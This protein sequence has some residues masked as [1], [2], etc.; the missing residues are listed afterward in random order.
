MQIHKHDTEPVL[1]KFRLALQYLNILLF[2][3]LIKTVVEARKQDFSQR[4]GA[5][6]INIPFLLTESFCG[7][8]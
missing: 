8:H 7:L 5:E 2:N 4:G 6:P 1:Q 3:L